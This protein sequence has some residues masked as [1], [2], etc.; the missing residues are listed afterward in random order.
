VTDGGRAPL[1]VNGWALY[2][3]PLFLDQVEA[4]ARRVAAIRAKDPDRARRSADAKRLKAIVTLA[5]E[6]IPQDPGRPE[7]RQGRTLGEDYK[8]WFR[9]K[10]FQQYRLFFRY[11]A[12]A[13]V[14]VHAWV[15]DTD[16]KRAY[17]SRDDAYR[18]FAGMLARGR[19]P[20][21]WDMLMREASAAGGRWRRV[22]AGSGHGPAA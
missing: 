11:H 14:I 18:V 1:I 15:N 6:I 3:H 7:Y 12:D 16:T 9:A 13:R 10:F 19:P 20:D 4:I 21:D 22:A 2:P 8:H 5:L 17:G